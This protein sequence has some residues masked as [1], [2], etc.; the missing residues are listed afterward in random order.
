M[1]D[2]L[3]RQLKNHLVVRIGKVFKETR[4]KLQLKKKMS[5]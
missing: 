3:R 5:G 4:I 1:I 2:T